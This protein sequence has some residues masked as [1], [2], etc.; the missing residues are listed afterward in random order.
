MEPILPGAPWLIAHKSMLGANKPSKITLNG[1]DYVLWQNQKGEVFALDNVCPHMQ[2]P[3]SDGWI[4]KERNTIACPFHALE[5]DGQGRLYQEDK[6]DV[7][8]VAKP[9]EIIVIG[10][11]I[12]TYGGF[13]RRLPIPDLIQRITEG[14]QFVG[15]AVEKSIPA[16]FLS[17]LMINYDFNHVHATHRE[18]FK[19]TPVKVSDYQENGYYTKAIQEVTRDE[20]TLEEIL[21]N[22]VLLV[23]PKTYT[24]YFEYA[25]PSTTSLVGDFPLGKTAS[26]FILYPEQESCTKTLVLLYVKTSNKL[27]LSLFKKPLLEALELVVEQDTRM[28]ENLY[29]RQKPKIRLPKEEIMFYA[30]KLYREW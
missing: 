11:L 3:L 8:P 22:P 16:D 9:L 14:F 15:V 5:F 24:N 20:N 26:F 27:L 21:K 4:C 12:W 7:K 6:A 10:D 18:P 23:A 30:E 13:E 25:F 19:I 1:Q 2:A 28:L 17:S 29:P